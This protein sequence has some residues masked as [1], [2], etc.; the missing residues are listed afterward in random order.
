MVLLLLLLLLLVTLHEAW[1]NPFGLEPLE[2]CLAAGAGVVLVAVLGEALIHG[3]CWAL[4]RRP[5]NRMAIMQRYARFKRWHLLIQCAVFFATLY[6]GWGWVVQQAETAWSIPGFKILMLA[7]LLA[8][9]V[10][11]WARFYDVERLNHEMLWYPEMSPF[12]SR[13][14]FLGLQARHHLLLLI[15]AMGLLVAQESLFLAVPTLKSADN[16]LLLALT[17]TTMLAAAL[18]VIPYFLRL[19]LGLRPLPDG[20][21]RQRL[22]RTA[23]RLGFRFNDILVWNTRK[24]IANAMVTGI[25]PWLRYIVVTDALMHELNDDEIEAVFGHEVGHMKHHH[26]LFYMVFILTSLFLLSGIW[27]ASERWVGTFD[28]STWLTDVV[29]PATWQ[30][31]SVWIVLLVVA[32]YML[33]VFGWLSRRCERQ[34][35]IFGCKTASPAAFINALEKVADLNGISRERPGFLAWWQHS[36]I[37]DRVD[38][39]RRME[40]DPALEPKFQRRL[41]WTKWGVA[42]GLIALLVLMRLHWEWDLT[43][44]M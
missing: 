10:I 17:A 15:P 36:T 41:G 44:L 16:T 13:W 14:A 35:D 37:A 3:A 7:P 33:I 22:L 42:L 6:G 27:S 9:L 28:A 21:L 5:G 38:F 43:R 19:F 8:G 29:P 30:I 12:L 32:V 31:I 1:F 20:P 23:T 18:V 2:I 40:G 25:T 24:G 11:G 4:R 39:I 26:I 34:A